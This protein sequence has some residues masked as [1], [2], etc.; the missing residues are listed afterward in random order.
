MVDDG[1]LEPGTKLL[2]E[3]LLSRLDPSG[4]AG[5]KSSGA[6]RRSSPPLSRGGFAVKARLADDGKPG[7]PCTVNAGWPARIALRSP[8]VC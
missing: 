2:S 7:L 1:K 6:I 5:V 4:A 3:D 8:F